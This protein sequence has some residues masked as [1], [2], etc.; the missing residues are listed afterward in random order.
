MVVDDLPLSNSGVLNEQVRVVNLEDG[1][2]AVV[3][4]VHGSGSTGVQVA[5]PDGNGWAVRTALTV[6]GTYDLNDAA[7]STAVALSAVRYSEADP[8]VSVSVTVGAL[9]RA[10]P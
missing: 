10:G 3:Y 5:T 4:F 8:T 6:D 1:T 2:P 9:R 7:D